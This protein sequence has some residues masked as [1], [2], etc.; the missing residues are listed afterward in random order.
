M[1]GVG[2]WFDALSGEAG[3]GV[4]VDFFLTD[5]GSNLISY[6]PVLGEDSAAPWAHC[7]PSLGQRPRN[8]SYE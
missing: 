1:T 4:E 6:W 5:G 8:S 3:G 7:H 2:G